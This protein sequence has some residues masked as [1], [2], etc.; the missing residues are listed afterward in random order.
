MVTSSQLPQLTPLRR[1]SLES[2]ERAAS[3]GNFGQALRLW[4][5]RCQLASPLALP[6]SIARRNDVLRHAA[7]I[8]DMASPS[9]IIRAAFGD[10]KP[11]LRPA[12]SLR[13]GGD[14]SDQ[15][16]Q[17][18]LL[19][20]TNHRLPMN[21]TLT[22]LIVVAAAAIAFPETFNLREAIAALLKHHV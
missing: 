12:R 16:A 7:A 9:A 2:V 19:R 21:W 18:V 8:G 3:A 13:I 6:S 14:K 20:R 10:V 15:C 5:V 1:P 22:H 17:R 4:S 11:Q